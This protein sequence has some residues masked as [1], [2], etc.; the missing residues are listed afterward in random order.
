M[1]DCR[2]HLQASMRLDAVKGLFVAFSTEEEALFHP[3]TEF[4]PGVFPDDRVML[5]FQNF[6]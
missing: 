3:M 6:L 5:S 4:Y 2:G 1:G